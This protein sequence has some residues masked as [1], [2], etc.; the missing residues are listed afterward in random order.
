MGCEEGKPEPVLFT[1]KRRRQVKARRRL[2]EYGEE[3]VVAEGRLEGCGGKVCN[4]GF[5]TEGP[6]L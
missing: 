4:N 2:L 6:L 3:E 1:S 5:L